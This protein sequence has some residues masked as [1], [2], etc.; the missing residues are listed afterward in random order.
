MLFGLFLLSNET[1]SRLEIDETKRSNCYDDAAYEDVSE[2][3]L[4]SPL[5]KVVEGLA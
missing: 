5:S 4:R 3:T 2:W 1:Y